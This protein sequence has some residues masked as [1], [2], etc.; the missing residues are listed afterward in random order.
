M[1][2]GDILLLHTDGLVEHQR[3]GEDYFPARLEDAI[4]RVKHEPAAEIYRAI[5][6]DL[7]T[8]GR[9]LDDVTLVVIKRV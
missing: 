9:L 2:K 5:T 7:L 1:G 4:R 8:F 3:D 6:E